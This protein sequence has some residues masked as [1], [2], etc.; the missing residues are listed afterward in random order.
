M[1]LTEAEELELLELEAAQGMPQQPVTTPEPITPSQQFAAEHPIART[2]GRT[3]RAALTGISSL[4]DTA[5]LVPKTAALGAGLGLEALGAEKMGAA[6][7][8][9]G[10][11]PSQAGATKSIIDTATGGMLKPNNWMDRAGDFTGELIASSMP[12]ASAPQ[13]VQSVVPKAPTGG[14]AI[15]AALD[16]QSALEQTMNASKP[17]ERVT[18]EAIKSQSRAAYDKA[19]QL[20]G[21]IKPE[22]VDSFVDD[23]E[24]T[25]LPQTRA[26]KI[27]AGKDSAVASLMSRIGELKGTQLNL[28][29]AQE[30][31]ELLGDVVDGMLEMGKPTKEGLKVIKIQDA[32]RDAIESADETK[33]IG[34][35]E[36]FDALKKARGLWSKAAKIS[37]IER[38]VS[39]AE[40]S[41]QPANAIKSGFKTLYNNPSRMRG[42]S[43]EQRDFIKKAANE[44]LALELLRGPAS[45]LFGIGSAVAGGPAGYIMGKGAEMGARGI[46]E[47]AMMGRADEL[48][49]MIAGVPEAA[50][51]PMLSQRPATALIGTTSGQGA[52][53]TQPKLLS[54]PPPNEKYNAMLR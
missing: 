14:S 38:I 5:L 41:E 21:A 42:L 44:G 34:G 53:F 18:S 31:D 13:V 36:G 51:S 22:I 19:K 7:Q 17:I 2:L 10:M 16:P 27:V 37:D 26:G 39:R 30:I 40:M 3:G 48:M 20:G 43:Q 11:L 47:K 25:V 15:R 9:V 1:P 29:E 50:Y 49:G 35:K 6:L 8:N 28:D 46:R 24:K 45:R 33:I 54:L 52:Q 12:F 23:I 4:V 32:L